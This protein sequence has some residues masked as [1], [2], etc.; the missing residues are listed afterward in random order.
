M[1]CDFTSFSTV[2]VSNQDNDGDNE[3]MCAMKSS[4]KDYRLQSSAGLKPKTVRF[5][6]QCYTY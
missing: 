4:W 2:F 5:A 1:A 3:R 6:S